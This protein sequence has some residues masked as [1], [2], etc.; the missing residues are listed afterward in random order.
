MTSPSPRRATVS[1]STNET[2]IFIELS[3]VGGEVSA[4][5]GVP[6]FDHMLD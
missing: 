6:F 3:L 4:A 1:R 2:K 5:T